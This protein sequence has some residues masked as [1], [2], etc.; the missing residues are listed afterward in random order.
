MNPEENGKP[1]KWDYFC[2]APGALHLLAGF[3]LSCFIVPA[4]I[5]SIPDN[6]I[7]HYGTTPFNVYRSM[8]VP[9]L[10]AVVGPL[11]LALTTPAKWPLTFLSLII[12][13]AGTFTAFSDL[14]I[15]L[16]HGTEPI[17]NY[18]APRLPALFG[19]LSVATGMLLFWV[20]WLIILNLTSIRRR[21]TAT[22]SNGPLPSTRNSFHPLPRWFRSFGLMFL[23][24][25]PIVALA[26]FAFLIG[27]TSTDTRELSTAQL[28]A[29]LDTTDSPVLQLRHRIHRYVYLDLLKGPESGL[30]KLPPTTPEAFAQSAAKAL[31]HHG[32]PAIESL[33]GA[34]SSPHHSVRLAAI[35]SLG[36]I[37][38]NASKAITPL[39]SL[40]AEGITHDPTTQQQE[41]LCVAASLA[42]LQIDPSDE[43]SNQAIAAAWESGNMSRLN[44]FLEE[45][46]NPPILR[47]TQKETSH[48]SPDHPRAQ[49]IL[50]QAAQ[51]YLRSLEKEAGAML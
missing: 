15:R 11:C 34:L 33:I 40:L 24:S 2:S 10:V 7:A 49:R 39:Q 38:K 27:H 29:R 13:L 48:W 47:P 3:I 14:Y 4:I 37:G 25:L 41:D 32:T 30:S 22:A 28:I 50:K 20:L 51:N 12:F 8:A 19:E 9:S 45:L 23:G 46:I 31:G 44:G 16:K 18:P 42:L 43:S 26:S 35:Q 6:G 17:L 36:Q 5:L 21:E 1:S